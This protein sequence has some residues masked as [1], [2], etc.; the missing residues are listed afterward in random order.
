MEQLEEA[1]LLSKRNCSPARY[2]GTSARPAIINRAELAGETLD[3][4]EPPLARS[5]E[6]L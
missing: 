4:E 2:P 3:A 6:D 1:E 5:S